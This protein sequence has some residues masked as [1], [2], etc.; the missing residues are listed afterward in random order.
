MKTASKQL[1]IMDDTIKCLALC[2]SWDNDRSW[3]AAVALNRLTV[4]NRAAKY[5]RIPKQSRHKRG[6][7]VDAYQMARKVLGWN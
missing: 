7:A 2:A 4:A 5:N 1:T 6:P 3:L